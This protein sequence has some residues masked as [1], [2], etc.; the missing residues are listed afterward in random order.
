M[1]DREASSI[2]I[3]AIS[4]TIHFVPRQET[5]AP[6][7]DVHFDEVYHA[8]LNGN[9]GDGRA[10]ALFSGLPDASL[11]RGLCG[12]DLP[13]RSEF[14]PRQVDFRVALSGNSGSVHPIP[15]RSVFPCSRSHTRHGDSGSIRGF[16]VSDH[17]TRT[18]VASSSLPRECCGPSVRQL[19]R[20]N[21]ST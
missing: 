14:F 10:M 3:R 7:K 4:S 11:S 17:Q 2:C 13:R 6:P 21:R 16:A 5:T 1:R 9:T 18:P 8:H 20:M 12:I 19:A 15:E